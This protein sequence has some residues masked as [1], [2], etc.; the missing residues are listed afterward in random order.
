[1]VD[2]DKIHLGVL[3]G[4]VIGKTGRIEEERP[5]SVQRVPSITSHPNG[6]HQHVLSPDLG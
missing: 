3:L 2:V 5:R 1:M 6:R 4:P